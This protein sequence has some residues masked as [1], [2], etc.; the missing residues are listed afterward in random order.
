MNWL[1]QSH[2]AGK[3]HVPN[4]F[5]ALPPPNAKPPTA[6]HCAVAAVGAVSDSERLVVDDGHPVPLP[7]RYTAT[8]GLGVIVAANCD[9]VVVES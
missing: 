4:A 2:C 5:Q 8:A 9:C 3:L 1:S 7:W 6:L